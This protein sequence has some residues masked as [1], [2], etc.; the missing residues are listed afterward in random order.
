MI[1]KKIAVIGLGD[2][3]LELTRRLFEEGH[4]V[5]AI[6]RN[7]ESVERIKDECAEAVCMDSNDESALRAQGLEEMDAVILTHS[8]NF[9][10]MLITADLCRSIG[11]RQIVARYRTGL[12]KRILQMLGIENIFNPEERAARNMAESFSHVDFHQTVNVWEH[13]QLTEIKIPTALIGLSLEES[14]LRE[15][16]NLNVLA[17]RRPRR[18]A[19]AA[20]GEASSA[21]EAEGAEDTSAG[22]GGRGME[23]GEEPG[24]HAAA[25]IF[26]PD[27]ASRLR[28]GD[29]LLAFGAGEDLDRF[30]EDHQ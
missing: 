19:H 1:R 12:H 25:R 7:M 15:S 9:E 27:N 5:L 29:V 13:Y 23:A 26:L 11:V 8:S 10:T 17:V 20:E 14:G 22:A 16:Y 28:K 30:F 2:F 4:E 6:D 18:T 3:G 21:A 24:D